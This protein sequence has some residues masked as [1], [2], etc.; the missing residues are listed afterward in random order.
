MPQ[1]LYGF[2]SASLHPLE[3]MLA[4]AVC[5]L[6]AAAVVAAWRQRGAT[7]LRYASIALVLFATPSVLQAPIV[8]L[9]LASDAGVMSLN[10]RFYY[11]AAAGFAL[12]AAAV[13]AVLRGRAARVLVVA[14]FGTLVVVGYATSRDIAARWRDTYAADSARVTRIGEALAAREFPPGCRIELAMPDYND[15]VRTHIDTMVKG[16]APRGASLLRC[17]VF[18]GRPVYNTV[19]DARDC[20]AGAWPG[21]RIAVANGHD[22]VDRFGNLCTLQFVEPDHAQHGP[23]I[24][25]F[26][27]DAQGRVAEPEVQP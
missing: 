21:L 17:A 11:L 3:I 18:A 8:R 23:G 5:A 15:D 13:V 2:A 7:A 27:I 22:L 14:T 1:A 10:L 6:A 26:S 16:A 4:L 25:H 12:A 9:A 20:T 24:F 19:V